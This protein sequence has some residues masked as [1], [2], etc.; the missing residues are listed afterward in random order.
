MRKTV[1][2]F[3]YGIFPEG[4]ILKI[5]KDKEAVKEAAGTVNGKTGNT[6]G[7]DG[8]NGKDSGG[9]VF[10]GVKRTDRLKRGTA[11]SGD[12]D[13]GKDKKKD[14]YTDKML[15]DMGTVIVF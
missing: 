10:S 5:G 12:P 7:D 14:R 8:R 4:Y 6:A 1:I 11:V 2:Y 3:L 15:Y 13:N 9:K